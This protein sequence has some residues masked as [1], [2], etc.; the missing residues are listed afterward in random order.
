M[1]YNNKKILVFQTDFSQITMPKES[2]KIIYRFIDEKWDRDVIPEMLEHS[3]GFG[4]PFG[5]KM[6]EFA[7]L[8]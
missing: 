5:D 2:S 8:S 4:F 3:V 1:L 6:P 7:F